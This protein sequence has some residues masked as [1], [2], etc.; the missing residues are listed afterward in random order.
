MVRFRTRWASV[1][2]RLVLLLMVGLVGAVGAL[3]AAVAQEASPAAVEAEGEEFPPEGVSFEFLG[4]GPGTVLPANPA[5]VVLFRLALEPGVSFP[6]DPTDPSVGLVAIESGALTFVVE[7]PITVLHPVVGG[8]PGPD[9]FETV[10]AGEEFTMEKGDS[11]VFPPN[12][13]GELRN[14]G[15]IAVSLLVALIAPPEAGEGAT[16]VAGTP[17]G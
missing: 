14:D 1:L 2:L 15:E 7:A 3:T 16:P 9:D 4:Y 8:F 12:V 5:D 10:P 17:E 6:A 13:A 11:A